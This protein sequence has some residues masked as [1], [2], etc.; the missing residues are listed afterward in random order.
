MCYS[1]FGPGT[2]Y[3]HLEVGPDGDLSADE[4]LEGTFYITS[5]PSTVNHTVNFSSKIYH[6]NINMIIY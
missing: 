6:Y 5:H 3:G 2:E 4:I 1:E